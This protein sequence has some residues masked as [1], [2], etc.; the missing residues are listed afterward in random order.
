MRELTYYVGMTLDGFIAGPSDEVDFYPLAD[1]HSA[2]MNGLYPEV[3]PTHVR[4]AV[5]IDDAPNRTFDTVI[6]GR[7]TYEPALQVGITSPYAHLRQ[8]VVSRTLN[9]SV[10]AA[11]EIVRDDPRARVRELKDEDGLGIY[12]AGGGRLAGELLPEIDRL[13]VKKYPVV[14]GSGLPAFVAGFAPTQL[15]L[16]DVRSFSNGCAVLSYRRA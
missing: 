14:A 13:I 11:V 2:Y 5:G 7:R 3:V 16:E 4:Q 8:V 6:M 10:E 9:S 1:D 12:L 15:D